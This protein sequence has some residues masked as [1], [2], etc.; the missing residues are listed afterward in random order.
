MFRRI[1]PCQARLLCERIAEIEP[2]PP[3]PLR[4]GE[5]VHVP[6]RAFCL[7]IVRPTV[8]AFDQ[9]PREQMMRRV[10]V[11]RDARLPANDR[12]SPIRA[13]H[14]PPRRRVFRPLVGVTK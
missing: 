6:L 9:H 7:R 14:Q 4:K 12:I 1:L 11:Q 2:H 3:V 13:H 10:A 5:E 8:R